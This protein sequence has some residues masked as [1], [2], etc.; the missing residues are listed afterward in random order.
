MFSQLRWPL[1]R[2]CSINDSEEG[3]AKSRV[4]KQWR[5]RA[6]LGRPK[7]TPA[8]PTCV[9]ALAD[10]LHLRLHCHVALAAILKDTRRHASDRTNAP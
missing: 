1:A 6:I 9:E 4:V 3:F 7:W 10:R 5:G 8:T 2:R